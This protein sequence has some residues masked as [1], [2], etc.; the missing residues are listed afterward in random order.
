M[1]AYSADP[2]RTNK[3]NSSVRYQAIYSCTVLNQN[4]DFSQ[5]KRKNINPQTL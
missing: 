5:T 3:K 4:K 2:Y 1:G